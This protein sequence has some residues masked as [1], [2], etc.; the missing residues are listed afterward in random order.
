MDLK[1]PLWILA[2]LLAFSL[3]VPPALDLM[4][5][6]YEEGYGGFGEV[7]EKSAQKVDFEIEPKEHQF[8]LQDVINML[9]VMDERTNTLKEGNVEIKVGNSYKRYKLQFD[10]NEYWSDHRDSIARQMYYDLKAAETKP[11]FKN[12][13]RMFYTYDTYGPLTLEIRVE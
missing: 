10:T 5:T 4:S 7:K 13:A 12:K 1:L 2:G 3:F 9:V 11:A 6:L 8:R